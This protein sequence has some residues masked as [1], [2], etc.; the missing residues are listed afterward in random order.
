VGS[1][2]P[3]ELIASL[4]ES[5]LHNADAVQAEEMSAY[6]KDR[7]QFFGIKAKLRKDIAQSW[8]QSL[9]KQLSSAERREIVLILFHQEQREF[10][11]SAID[12]MNAWNKVAIEK[13]DADL[14]MFLITTHSWWDS[15]DA[16]ASNYLGKYIQKFPIEGAQLIDEWRNSGNIWLQRSCLIHQLKY[17]NETNFSLLSDLIHQFKHEKEFFI[18]KAIGWSLRQYSKFQPEAVRDFL[19]DSD[20]KGLARK[21]AEKYIL[22]K[23]SSAFAD[24]KTKDRCAIRLNFSPKK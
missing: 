12:W 15:V 20:L 10:H 19:H 6:M 1:T 3:C 9:P 13:D 16:V 18:Q 21:E 2:N 4:K 22:T 11:Y 23:D 5:F 7:F 14:L 17:G 8:L 24:C